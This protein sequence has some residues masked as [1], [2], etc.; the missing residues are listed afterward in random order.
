M[1][2]AQTGDTVKIHYTGKLTDQSVFD[3][4]VNREPLEFTIGESGIINGLQQAV[5]G[6]GIGDKKSIVV[7]PEEAF[8]PVREE[9][10]VDV[11]REHLPENI[12]PEVGEQLRVQKPDGSF[13][14]VRI[15]HTTDTAVTIDANHPLA[16]Q[17]LLFDVELVEIA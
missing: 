4:S 14:D 15:T 12:T 11:D 1:K 13:I 7:S 6:M 17:T 9:L 3:S 2:L 16:G 8:G 5:I 10:I